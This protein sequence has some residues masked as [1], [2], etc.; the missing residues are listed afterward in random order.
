MK[1]ATFNINNVD[2][3]LPNLLGRVDKFDP[4]TG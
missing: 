2:R 3:R 4:V 1:L